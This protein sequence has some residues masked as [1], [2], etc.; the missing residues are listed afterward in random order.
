MLAGTGG[1]EKLA[2]LMDHFADT[3]IIIYAKLEM[4]QLIYP[5]LDSVPFLGKI[6]TIAVTVP[7]TSVNCERAISISYI[8]TLFVCHVLHFDVSSS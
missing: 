8:T 7:I 1:G 3:D 2:V 6:A 5:A 4:A